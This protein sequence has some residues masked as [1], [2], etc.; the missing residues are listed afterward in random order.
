MSQ[1]PPSA[2]VGPSNVPPRGPVEEPAGSPPARTSEDRYRPVVYQPSGAWRSLYERFFAHI[3]LDER[4][5]RT[6]REQAERGLVVYVARSLSFLDFLALD[7]LTKKHALPLVRFTNDVGMFVAEPFGRGSR[8]MRL[9]KQ[10]PDDQALLDTLEGEH[11]ALLF[12]RRPPR[13]QGNGRKGDDMEVDLIRTLVELQRKTS[14]PIV[15]VPQTFVWTKRPASPQRRSAIDLIFG[16][17]EWPGRIRVFLQFLANYK[18]SLLRSGEPFDV[19]AFLEEHQ[20]MTDAQAADAIRYAL[21]RR[22]ERERALV[23]GPAKKTSTRIVDELM[24][25]PR[26]RKHVEHA[27]KESKREIADVEAEARRDLD[28][29]CAAPDTNV[30]HFF[31]RF[32]DTVVW[33]RIYDGMV[34]DREGLERVREAARKGPLVL[35][36]S[37][38]SHVDYLV[39]SD[40]LYRE[41]L[42]PPLIA[43]GD[44]LSFFPLGPFLR[45]SGAFFIKRSFKGKK[46]Y[47]QLVDAYVR[48]ILVE[49]WNLELFV[50]GGRSR[51][52]KLLSPKLGILSMIVDAALQLRDREITFVPISI[53]YERII[54]EKSYV[55]E[56]SG[57][58][59]QPESIGG[60][61]ATS[62]VLRSKYGRLYLQFGETMSFRGLVDEAVALAG[63]N[64]RARGAPSMPN[65]E[66]GLSP[67]QRRA[68]VQ[69]IAHRVTYEINRATVV[70]PAALC[71]TALM[72]HRRRG[73]THDQLVRQ[74]RTMLAALERL[75]ARIAKPVIDDEGRFRP[76]TLSESLRLFEDA[77]LVVTV[78]DG[79]GDPKRGE[80]PDEPIYQIPEERR[81][82]LE[83]HK[84][85]VLHFFVPSAL[86]SSALLAMNGEAELETLRDR[87]R[88]LS[89][90]FKLEFMYRADAEF[91]EIFD[92]ALGSMRAAGEVEI[93]GSMV[94]RGG[95]ASSASIERY[96]EMLR[97]YF[98]SYRLAL[99]SVRALRNGE[100]A[101]FGKKEWL[102]NALALGQRRYLSG[103]ITLRESVARPK[104]E[105]A[106]AALHDH[107]VVRVEGDHIKPGAL[108]DDG[109]TYVELDRV[110]IEHLVID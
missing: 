5:E 27:A 19:R 97:S 104:L 94:R 38:K 33:N 80:P 20:D 15:L 3:K 37:H 65:G 70:T 79:K 1:L 16:P 23:L 63:K 81:I 52:G 34:V 21:L 40:L 48:K 84:N 46:L 101:S 56:Q 60:L 51:T 14:K 105:N 102:K 22:M 99:L 78:D 82:A 4:W 88:R 89:R 32:L 53:G 8:R 24:R 59:K 85:T 7:F 17:A 36:P 25:S 92:D 98:E 58:E 74:A 109:T 90:L 28:K 2:A 68:L 13:L 73:I 26:L 75:G 110:L 83:Y 44:N 31:H 106:L 42:A 11:S 12:L 71:A 55:H 47:P 10:I 66:S 69:R 77:K 67:S 54:E 93:A 95:G 18:N 57:G 61:L 96:A 41:G 50:E 76:E 45:R 100:I 91:D 64:D 103:Q 108:I 86:I 43:A 72:A 107:Q 62:R 35:L 9:Q 39:V 49:G 6:V 29:L 30:V 87:V